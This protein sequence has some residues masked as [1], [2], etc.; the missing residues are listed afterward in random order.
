MN[1]LVARIER[2][3]REGKS[4]YEKLLE[5]PS[6][7]VTGIRNIGCARSERLPGLVLVTFNLLGFALPFRLT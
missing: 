3:I 7:Q 4:A 2:R 6:S 1:R 5:V